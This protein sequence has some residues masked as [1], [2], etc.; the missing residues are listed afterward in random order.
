M[1]SVMDVDGVSNSLPS[2]KIDSQPLITSKSS[3][4][5]GT[6]KDVDMMSPSNPVVSNSGA[7]NG[8]NT[9]LSLSLSPSLPLS[10]T[11]IHKKERKTCHSCS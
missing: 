10:S 5:N 6:E 8:P 1:D 4:C 11:H 7:E 2:E 9:G 3:Q